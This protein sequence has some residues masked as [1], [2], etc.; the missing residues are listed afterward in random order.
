MPST[1]MPRHARAKK[2]DPLDAAIDWYV[3]L[4]SGICTPEDQTAFQHWLHQHPS[5]HTAWQQL[6]HMGQTLRAVPR[7][8]GQ[9]QAARHAILAAP[10]QSRRRFLKQALGLGAAAT[11]LHLVTTQQPWKQRL[12]ADI[13]T[14]VGEHRQIALAHGAQLWMNTRSAI[15]VSTMAD[16]QTIKLLAGEIFIDTHAAIAPGQLL[17]ET[18]HGVVAP[19][20]TVFGVRLHDASA[21]QSARTSVSVAQ[22]QVAIWPGKRL[23]TI[24]ASTAGVTS[25]WPH[26]RYVSAGQT[27][28]FNQDKAMAVQARDPARDSWTQG[29]FSVVDMRLDELATELSRYR[30]GWIHCHDTLADL[31]ITGT[32]PLR[33]DRDIALDVLGSLTRSFPLQ[34]KQ[35]TSYWVRI[36][37][38][39]V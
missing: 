29:A 23:N 32:W 25:D 6:Q 17:V 36:E 26:A 31:R 4:T 9:A 24:S 34:L 15:D 7:E 20:G 11:S 38:L 28:D 39:D 13:R 27:L 19:Q 5:H 3:C 18:A 12:L 14:Q 22:G 33:P 35:M 16:V 2:T 10:A 37:P 30:R 21:H 1:L 8:A